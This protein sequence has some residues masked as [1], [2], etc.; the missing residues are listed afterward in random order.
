M[1]PRLVRRIG[2]VIPD[3]HDVRRSARQVEEDVRRG[4]PFARGIAD[5]AGIHIDGQ[6]L[7]G[8]RVLGRVTQGTPR[9]AS[10]GWRLLRR[11]PGLPKD[12]LLDV[13]LD[14]LPSRSL[15]AAARLLRLRER[16]RSS[17]K[18]AVVGR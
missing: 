8:A 18:L 15:I 11:R 9:L 7:D 14:N 3:L 13:L 17:L 10:S 4:H 1:S 6:L 2:R 12:E 16:G 5:R